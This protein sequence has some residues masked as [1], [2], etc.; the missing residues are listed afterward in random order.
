MLKLSIIVWGCDVCQ[1]VC[2]HNKKVE[3]T[4]IEE[5]RKDLKYTIE[6]EEISQISNKEFLR[7]YKDRAFSWRGRAII[8]RNHEIIH[9]LNKDKG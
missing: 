3:K 4:P 8:V 6:Y 1:D 2:P 9:E 7:R 5:F